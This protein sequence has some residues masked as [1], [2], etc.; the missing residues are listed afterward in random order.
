V[1]RTADEVVAAG[2]AYRDHRLTLA[3]PRCAARHVVVLPT[4]LLVVDVACPGCGHTDALGPTA[5][6]AAL[7]RLLPALG[8]D[9]ADAMNARVAATV[10]GWCARPDVRA[11]LTHDGVDLAA[12][13]ATELLPLILDDML[14]GDD[15]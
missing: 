3:C 12:C 13:G 2:V 11:A 8:R 5:I 9:G 6:A 7:D 4:V 14:A 15:A 1:A 10:R